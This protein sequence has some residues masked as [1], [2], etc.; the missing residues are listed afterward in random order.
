MISKKDEAILTVALTNERIASEIATRTTGAGQGAGL[1]AVADAAD[2]LA[3]IDDSE[4]EKK[5]IREYLTVALASRTA[6]NEIADQ[7]ELFV[8]ILEYQA[9]NVLGNNTALNAAQDKLAPLSS[10]TREILVVAMANRAAATRV[11]D[12]IDASGTSL[13]AVVDAV[14]I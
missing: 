2:K 5:E 7:L 10:A 8:E 13:A 11:A 12:E 4:K 9:A 6:A 1:A 14:V 3:I